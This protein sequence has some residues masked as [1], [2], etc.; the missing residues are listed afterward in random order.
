MNF[1]PLGLL[2]KSIIAKSWKDST[3]F[4]NALIDEQHEFDGEKYD[5]AWLDVSNWYVINDQ[6]CQKGIDL[7]AIYPDG[8]IHWRYL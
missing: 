5:S 4:L 7:P 8:E 2:G 6:G 3:G 1:S